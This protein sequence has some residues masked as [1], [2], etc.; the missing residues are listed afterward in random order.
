MIEVERND[1]DISRLFNWG[2][3][4]DITNAEG[5]VQA[6]VYMKLMGDADVNVARVH[7]IR[8]SADLRR[9]LLD[10]TS[11]ERVVFIKPIDALEMEDL[12][13]LITVFSM[14]EITGEAYKNVQVRKPVAPKSNANLAKMEKYQKEVDEYPALFRAAVEK[15][16]QSEVAKLK[17]QL[18]TETHESL[19]KK[20]VATLTDE[21]C[22]QEALNS[23]KNIEVYLGCYK[24]DSYKERLFASFEEYDNIP[25]EM[26]NE[27]RSAYDKLDIRVDELKKLRAATQ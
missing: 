12:L 11:D 25:T 4:Y 15:Q 9:K 22:E 26:K 27:F 7:A 16:M 24:D 18:K 23:Y 5:E 2:R 19:Y 6:T 1:V 14:R 10:L 17:V 13:N 8:K 3:K 20:Y 21:L